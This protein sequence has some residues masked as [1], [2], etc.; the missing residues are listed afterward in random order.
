[1]LG[2]GAPRKSA[3]AFAIKDPYHW[4]IMAPYA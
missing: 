2:A 1:M 3:K 4:A